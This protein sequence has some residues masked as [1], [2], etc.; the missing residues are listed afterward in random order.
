MV[1]SPL[2]EL[3]NINPEGDDTEDFKEME[4]FYLDGHRILWNVPFGDM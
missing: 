1:W 2:K 4:W 3:S